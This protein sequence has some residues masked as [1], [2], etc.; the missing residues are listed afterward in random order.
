M[1]TSCN[2]KHQFATPD[3]RRGTVLVVNDEPL[4]R[5]MVINALEAMGLSVISAA[6]G[7]QAIQLMREAANGISLALVDVNM[8]GMDRHTHA[9]AL[10]ALVHNVP[11]L[12]MSGYDEQQMSHHGDTTLAD[13]FFAEN[14]R[15]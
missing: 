2:R 15:D 13:D 14:F 12:M 7:P 9:T 6:S 10:R 11:I 5:M 4:V 8:P 3:V 1:S